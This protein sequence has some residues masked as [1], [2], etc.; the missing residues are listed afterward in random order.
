MDEKEREE[1]LAA[2]RKATKRGQCVILSRTPEGTRVIVLGKSILQTQ[3]EEIAK[4]EKV[5][6]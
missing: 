2:I 5:E 4:K 3:L 1:I 6:L